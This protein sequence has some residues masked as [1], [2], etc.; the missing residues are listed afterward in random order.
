APKYDGQYK[1]N[2]I[3]MLLTVKLMFEWLG[4]GELAERL[5][6]AIAKVIK[7]HKV[8]TYDV[9]MNNTTLEVAEEVARNL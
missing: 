3:A 1:V 6:H 4:E 5:E 7:E 2:P 9:G 8:G